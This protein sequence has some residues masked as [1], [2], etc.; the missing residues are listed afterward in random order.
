MDG[1]I[2]LVVATSAFGMGVDKADVRTV[3]HYQLPGTI[4]SY[5]QEAGRGGR[6]GAPAL[7]VALHGK[8]DGHLLRAFVDRS[9]PPRAV[10]DRVHGALV[11]EVGAG[12]RARVLVVR[13]QERRGKRP[14][15]DDDTLRSAVLALCRTGAVRIYGETGAEGTPDPPEGS[16]ILDLGVRRGTPDFGPAL[17][18]RA[19]A[20]EGLAAVQAYAR[21]G[22]C[23]RRRLLAYFGESGEKRCGACDVCL[24][25]DAKYTPQAKARWTGT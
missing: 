11:R 1:R 4:E 18:L 21:R 13:L 24:E 17:R 5:Y 9:R 23:R 25:A 6:D 14:P 7:C 8:S 12:E 22:G 16:S 15:L 2:R 3:I 19:A 10:L 20:L